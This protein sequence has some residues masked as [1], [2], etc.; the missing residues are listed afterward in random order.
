MHRVVREDQ[1]FIKTMPACVALLL[2][3]PAIVKYNG[4]QWARARS[5]RLSRSYAC[6]E[7]ATTQPPRVSASA[8]SFL[9]VLSGNNKR[10]AIV[11]YRNDALLQ[12]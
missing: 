4:L 5:I 2:K 1:R 10:I 6:T 11:R 7:I 8:Y 3:G 12:K 9:P